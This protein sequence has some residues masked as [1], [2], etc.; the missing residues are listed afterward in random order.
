M[1][2]LTAQHENP[3]EP[4]DVLIEPAYYGHGNSVKS[5][6]TRQF[7][8]DQ[9]MISDQWLNDCYGRWL[10]LGA[11]YRSTP[12]HANW[13][14][15]DS[16][17]AAVH[18]Q[19]GLWHVDR[20]DRPLWLDLN[21][22]W[23][24]MDQQAQV[25]GNSVKAQNTTQLTGPFDGFL[26]NHSYHFATDPELWLQNIQSLA[27]THVMVKMAFLDGDLLQD[28]IPLPDDGYIRRINQDQIEVYYPWV[29]SK[30]RTEALLSSSKIIQL[31]E[32]YGWELLSLTIQPSL[33]ESH[34]YYPIQAATVWLEMQKS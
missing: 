31:W 11:G 18:V 27:S 17:P 12:S 26:L 22:N 6:P 15:V 25:L 20:R 14:H 1:D 32:Q 2:L 9:K 34:P 33:D 10:N 28:C 23:F 30:P 24:D 29:Q 3:W 4:C 16:D 21:I 13:I 19:G 8:R 7:L 5:W